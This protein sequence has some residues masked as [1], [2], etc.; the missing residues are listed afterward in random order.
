[1]TG[2]HADKMVTASSQRRE[3]QNS[4]CHRLRT[5]PSAS[6]PL[7]GFQPLQNAAQSQR[8][9]TRR[10]LFPASQLHPVALFWQDKSIISAASKPVEANAG[11]LWRCSGTCTRNWGCICL[12]HCQSCQLPFGSCQKTAKRLLV[13]IEKSE[14]LLSP[15]LTPSQHK[16]KGKNSKELVTYTLHLFKFSMSTL[17]RFGPNLFVIWA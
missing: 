16:W 4:Q 7:Q 10:D 12:S 17:Q 11:A 9:S 2:L 5:D 14:I 13:N 3:G 1:M 6:L 15:F 8:G